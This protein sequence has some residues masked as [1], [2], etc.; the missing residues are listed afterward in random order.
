VK[1]VSAAGVQNKANVELM[2]GCVDAS[3][4]T[5]T[6]PAIFRTVDASD[7]CSQCTQLTL[8]RGY[9]DV[10][11][12]AG[13]G[14]AT[15]A[16]NYVCGNYQAS[17]CFKPGLYVISTGLVGGNDTDIASATSGPSQTAGTGVSFVVGIT[18]QPRGSG[19][20]TGALTLDCCA[21]EMKNY[22]LLYHTAGCKPPYSDASQQPPAAS[23][24]DKRL[25]YPTWPGWTCPTPS[26]SNASSAF[27]VNGLSL[28]GNN[29]VQNYNGTVFSPY[30]CASA[31]FPHGDLN[32]P[33]PCVDGSADPG[34]G[35]RLPQFACGT[36]TD[37]YCIKAGGGT[38]NINGQLIAPSIGMNGNGTKVSPPSGL[39][40]V[41][42]QPY[43]A[44]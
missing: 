37:S 44:E 43:L 15:G 18:F 35:T 4:T 42:Q 31:P 5:E 25:V 33:M 29:S 41:G 26:T 39:V 27:P 38:V 30:Q 24:G 1:I 36:T 19:G 10:I 32:F 7:N 2:G 23:G 20:G 22:V 28:F 34:P 40:A 13:I 6:G 21:P 11:N 9:Y 12:V 17:I 14:K 3:C 8:Q 16:P